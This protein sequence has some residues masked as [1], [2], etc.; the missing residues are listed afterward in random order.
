[1]SA[2]A[3]E[4]LQAKLTQVEEAARAATP[5]PWFA[6][7]YDADWDGTGHEASIGTQPHACKWPD[8]AADIVGHGYEGGGVERLADAQFIAASSPDVVLRRVA[9]DRQ[10]LAEHAPGGM[11]E[12]RDETECRVCS[13]PTPGFSGSWPSATPCR[14]VLL[15]AEGWGWTAP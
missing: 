14:T 6:N 2:D 13:G 12:E 8:A 5:G 11:A 1:M 3:V 9:A 15:L 7:A 4:W 10:I